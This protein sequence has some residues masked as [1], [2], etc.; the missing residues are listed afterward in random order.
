MAKLI[1][2][3]LSVEGLLY[4]MTGCIVNVNAGNGTRASTLSEKS[5]Q[6][7]SFAKVPVFARTAAPAAFF[8]YRNGK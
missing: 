3:D 4:Q 7:I 6:I 8:R 1:V 5:E 2:L